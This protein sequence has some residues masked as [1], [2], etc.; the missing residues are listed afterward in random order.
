MDRSLHVL[1]FP[2]AA[3]AVV[4]VGLAF[5]T[6][7]TALAWPALLMLRRRDDDEDI[8]VGT[9]GEYGACA[10]QGLPNV[11]SVDT[12]AQVGEV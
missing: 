2:R 5:I 4:A 1:P 9:A 6:P 8:I 11:S 10:A 7:V 12:T 3:L